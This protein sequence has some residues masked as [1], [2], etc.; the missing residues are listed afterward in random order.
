MPHG[1]P[2]VIGTQPERGPAHGEPLRAPPSGVA[3]HAPHLVPCPRCGTLNGR[4]AALCWGCDTDLRLFGRFE[5]A[6]AAEPVTERP[7]EP[8]ARAVPLAEGRPG[9]H[10]VSRAGDPASVQAVADAVAPLNTADLPVLTLF[11]EG[12]GPLAAARPLPSRRL[13][14]IAAIAGLTLVGAAA[15]LWWRAPAPRPASAAPA[16]VTPSTPLMPRLAESPER[17][18][19]VSANDDAPD[20]VRLSFP[21]LEV[22]PE[23]ALVIH[24]NGAAAGSKAGQSNGPVAAPKGSKARAAARPAAA[25]AACTSNMAALGF[26]TLDPAPAKE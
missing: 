5:A 18:F 8:V 21:P 24:P 9:L 10:L 23:S 17:P 1:V 13:R 20:R 3:A 22:V 11:V 16:P 14:V 26:C 7:P 19:S 6:V 4:S 15:A 25:P 2:P 12:T